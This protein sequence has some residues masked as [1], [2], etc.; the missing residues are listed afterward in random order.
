MVNKLYEDKI[1]KG[2]RGCQKQ[3]EKASLPELVFELGLEGGKLSGLWGKSIPG[4]STSQCKGPG[5]V[6]LAHSR[7]SKDASV[8]ECRIQQGGKQQARSWER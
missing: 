1:R 5:T 3:P 6:C 2:A 7:T 8:N 4:R